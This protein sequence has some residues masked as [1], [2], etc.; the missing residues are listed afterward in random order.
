M[1]VSSI[2][3]LFSE[4]IVSIG[5]FQENFYQRVAME[6]VTSALLFW[7]KFGDHPTIVIAFL[8]TDVFNGRV[9]SANRCFSTAWSLIS[10]SFLTFSTYLVGSSMA[11]AHI[12]SVNISQ[13]FF[14]ANLI[15]W[16]Y[17]SHGNTL[18]RFSSKEFL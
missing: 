11:K 6:T 13:R 16:S 17:L 7:S 8:V 4:I 15:L 14:L 18:L 3:L 2:C 12:F 1:Y 5:Y 9:V 10:F